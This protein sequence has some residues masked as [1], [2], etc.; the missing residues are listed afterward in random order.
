[1]LDYVF[2]TFWDTLYIQKSIKQWYL[3]EEIEN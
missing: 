1:M 3:R 2:S